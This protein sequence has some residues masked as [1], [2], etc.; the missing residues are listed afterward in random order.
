MYFY[1]LNSTSKLNIWNMLTICT[2]AYAGKN[3]NMSGYLYMCIHINMHACKHIDIHILGFI[4]LKD[5]YN[6]LI[7]SITLKMFKAI[8]L[9]S[10]ILVKYI[11]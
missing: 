1:V 10:L 8:N 11:Q 3:I 6:S 2:Y 7:M 4:I 9:N 5:I